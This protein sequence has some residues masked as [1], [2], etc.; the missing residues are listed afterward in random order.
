MYILIFT[1]TTVYKKMKKTQIKKRPMADTTLATLEPEATE[2]RELDG[3]NLY[4]RV[5]PD[6]KKAWLF[7]YK[8]P[9]GKWSWL[10]IGGYPEVSGQLARQKA[11]ELQTDISKGNNPLLTKQQ[12]KIDEIAASKSTF[13]ALF[14]EW[15]N[16]KVTQT[17][18]PWTD[19]T[20]KRTKAA[21]ENHILPVM[22]IRLFAGITPHE[23]YTLF[24]SIQRKTNKQGKPII[25]QAKRVRQNCHEM[26]DLA[27]ITGRINYNPLE[28]IHKFL[29]TAKAENMAHVTANDLPALLRA[30]RNYATPNVSIGLQLLSMLFPRPSELREARWAEFDLDA[31]LWTIPA[32]RMKRR[33]E[34]IIP[35]PDQAIA[36]L[37]E[38]KYYSGLSSYLFPS[39]KRNGKSLFLSDMTFT[40][41]LRRMGYEGRQTPHGFRHIASTTLN[42]KGFD[43][44]HIEAAL[45]HV[46]D[47]VA[48]VYNKAAY[49][50][51]RIV[52]LQWW[53][54]YL[55][56]LADDS[57]IQLKHA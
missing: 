16:G 29:E 15:F 31:K 6:G 30:I 56:K 19:G 48:G 35:L 23:W 49:L 39:R 9:D 37:K 46:K 20:A 52:M 27:K 41:A 53:A 22:G 10:G 44:N 17:V 47:G 26:Y 32:A 50:E 42:E 13:E 14:L 34:H 8:K 43:E 18:S 21:I 4:F 45:S 3:N 7:R 11:S 28:G 51:N 5:K 25:D 2:Y 38:L 1:E 40:Q 12:K 36:L 54:D 24:Q 33:R 55:D 57:V